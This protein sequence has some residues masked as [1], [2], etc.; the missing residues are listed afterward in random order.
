M[1]Y[2]RH[3]SRSYRLHWMV[4]VTRQSPGPQGRRW[5][6]ADRSRQRHADLSSTCSCDFNPI[7]MAFAKLKALLRKAAGKPRDAL[8]DTIDAGANCLHSPRSRQL[9]QARG[10]CTALSPRML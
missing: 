5:A 1:E 9:R 4:V 3:S 7:E 8:R 10:I 2:V 6:K